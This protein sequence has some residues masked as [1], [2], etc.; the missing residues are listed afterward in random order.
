MNLGGHDNFATGF[1][2][3]S[4]ADTRNLTIL[5][6]N[7]GLS[8]SPFFRITACLIDVIFYILSLGKSDSI[9]EKHFARN[10]YRIV[11]LW[12][13]EHIALTK[14]EVVVGTRF[15]HSLFEIDAYIVARTD[16]LLQL[17]HL[18]CVEINL[19]IGNLLLK[20]EYL[21]GC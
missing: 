18:E 5:I 21:V 6:N 20:L 11:I 15:G 12:N 19:S 7:I 14:Y 17:H 4:L 8:T 2:L 1:G 9:G 13:K 16:S 3:C 10:L